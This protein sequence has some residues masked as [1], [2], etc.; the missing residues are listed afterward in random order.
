VSRANFSSRDLQPDKNV[1]NIQTAIV[2]RPHR[3]GDSWV[4]GREQLGQQLCRG[5][6]QGSFQGARSLH[7]LHDCGRI[8][9]FHGL[10]QLG[11]GC[12]HWTALTTFTL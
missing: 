8:P 6:H 11:G 5:E 10:L 12:L 4:C 2:S 3:W 1:D 7:R 9:A